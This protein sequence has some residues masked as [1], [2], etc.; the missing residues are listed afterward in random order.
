MLNALLIEQRLALITGYIQELE[1]IAGSE[2]M[3][4]LGIAF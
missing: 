4:S 1:K 2:R 3:T